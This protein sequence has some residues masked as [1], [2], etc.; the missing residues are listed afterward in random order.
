MLPLSKNSC[1]RGGIW[2]TRR[3]EVPVGQPRGGSSPLDHTKY[4][5]PKQPLGCF[6][7]NNYRVRRAGLVAALANP[8]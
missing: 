1:S 6:G 5:K 3:L 8:W 4:R 7:I 2:Y